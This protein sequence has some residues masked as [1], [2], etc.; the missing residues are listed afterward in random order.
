MRA[1]NGLK[2]ISK[3]TFRKKLKGALLYILK[4]ED[5]YIDSDKIMAKLKKILTYNSSLS[6]YL[7]PI[8]I[9][10]I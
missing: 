2:N 4:I 5:S 1:P 8:I 9:V 10:I 3:K 6:I 7:V